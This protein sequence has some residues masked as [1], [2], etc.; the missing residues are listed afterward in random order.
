M[1]DTVVVT[2]PE[3]LWPRRGD[4]RG[5]IV[6][7]LKSQG[8]RVEPGDPVAEV[9]I[10]KAI[11]VVESPYEGIVEDVLVEPGDEIRPGAGLVRVRPGGEGQAEDKA[12]S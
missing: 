4:W 5:R 7:I 10:E 9:E 12:R 3:D 6:A 8:D 1:E 2:V 11:L